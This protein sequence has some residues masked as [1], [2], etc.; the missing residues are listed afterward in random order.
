MSRKIKLSINDKEA[1]ERIRVLLETTI[2]EKPSLKALSRSAGMNLDKLK[3]GF[4][5]L[6][7]YP[8]YRY[9]C[10]KKIQYAKKLLLETEEPVNAIAWELGYEHVSSFCIEF[11]KHAGMSPL[12]YRCKNDH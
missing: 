10:L 2:S 12:K 7:G 1:L 11:K 5:L 9:Y 4:K 6:Y 3:K 8:P